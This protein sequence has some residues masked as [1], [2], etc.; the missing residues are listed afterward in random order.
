MD[1]FNSFF[2]KHG[3][4]DIKIIGMTKSQLLIEILFLSFFLFC[5]MYER[6][7][8]FVFIS[9]MQVLYF[10]HRYRTRLSCRQILLDTLLNIQR[11]PE[12]FV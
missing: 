1:Y 2:Q 11:I 10:N 6:H 3:S 12:K 9:L 4:F 8:F 7:F 5:K